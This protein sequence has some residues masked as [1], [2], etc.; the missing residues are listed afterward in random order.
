MVAVS[1]T[2][3]DPE[4]STTYS[5]FAYPPSALPMTFQFHR[6][7]TG[8][9]YATRKIAGLTENLL[10]GARLGDCSMSEGR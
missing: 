3:I 2:Y 5:G 9:I 6:D 10:I 1:S 8:Q 4:I 7:R